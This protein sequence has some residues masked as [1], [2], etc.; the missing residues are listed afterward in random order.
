MKAEEPPGPDGYP[1]VGNLPQLR[2]SNAFSF[3]ERCAREYDGDVLKL[4]SVR[5]SA[6]VLT[7]P[8]D[9]QQVLIT[10][11]VNYEKGA[12]RPWSR[13]LLGNGLFLS[14]GE[15]WKRQ[16]RLL[17]PAFLGDQVEQYVN[18][19]VDHAARMA[20][21]YRDGQVVDVYEDMMELT[22][23][24][25][26]DVLFGLDETDP[27]AEE[28][29]EAFEVV[30]DHAQRIGER[31]VHVPS[32]LPTPANRRFRD[33]LDTID[34][35]VYDAIHRR[36]NADDR[37]TDLLSVIFESVESSDETM[38]DRELRDELM[39]LLFAGHETSALALSYTWLLL[40]RN[41]DASAELHAEIDDVLGDADP[42][43][44]DLP[45]LDWTAGVVKESMRIYP[46]V[47]AVVRE[48]VDD[49]TVGGYPVPG[50]TLIVAP[51]WLVHRDPRW[52]DDPTAFDPGRWTDAFED[53]LHGQAYFPFGAGPRTCIG[54]VLAKME[55][56]LVV[57]TMAREIGVDPV[58]GGD[59]EFV[60]A[61][62]TRP[63]DG[64]RLRVRSRD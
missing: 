23:A 17:Q 62:T 45:R 10:N 60:P 52:Y 33:A 28:F 1:V 24:I 35:V 11:A 61:V 27:R 12:F 36:R 53:R 43:V 39:S 57:A 8:A 47:Y 25:M 59:P 49:D 37:P 6:Y 58:D 26:A 54:N 13:E 9:I 18:A 4:E 14:E 30:S 20:E 48:A 5:K 42:T 21:S 55:M 19:A 41:P 44:A 3:L 64:V 15:F 32:W 7:D 51:Q 22:L 56:K 2:R 34:A 29:F 46:P 31:P 50:G 40:A 38:T 16:R 63:R